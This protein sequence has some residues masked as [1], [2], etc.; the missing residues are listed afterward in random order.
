[1]AL[2]R[3]SGLQCAGSFLLLTDGLVAQPGVG[4]VVLLF[5]CLSWSTGNVF[6]RLLLRR[7][8]VPPDLV[9][10]LR[11]LGGLPVF[12]VL[13]G[14]TQLEPRGDSAVSVGIFEG[15]HTGYAALNGV[16]SVMVWIFL[17]RTLKFATASY[18]TAMC[19]LTPVFVMCLAIPFL[20]EGLSPV[21]FL[22][23][24]LIVSASFL[25]HRLRF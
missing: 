5:A 11:P 2:P 16:C 10:L 7:S 21:Q 14:V 18:M 6:I 3:L 20:G 24:A 19:S 23:G 1:M 9:S 25:V 15:V 22:G 4:E 17:N 8:S 12:L 13:F